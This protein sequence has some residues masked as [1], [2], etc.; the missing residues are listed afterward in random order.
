MDDNVVVDMH[1]LF[2]RT[3][4]NS[5]QSVVTYDWRHVVLSFFTSLLGC[6]TTLELLQRRTSTKGGYNWQ[7]GLPVQSPATNDA[8]VS[9]HSIIHHHGRYRYLGNAFRR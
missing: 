1:Q 2:A 3:D 8:Q 4:S 5:L 7:V 6:I 9:P